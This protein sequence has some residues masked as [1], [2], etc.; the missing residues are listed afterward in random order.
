ML[1]LG[2]TNNMLKNDRD[3]VKWFNLARQ[4]PDAKIAAEASRAYHNLAAVARALSHHGVGVPDV[5]DA[6][7]RS[8]RLRAG[9]DGAASAGWFVHPYLSVR[10]V[11][12]THGAVTPGVGFAPQYLSEERGDRGARRGHAL[13]ARRD[14]MVRSRRSCALPDPRRP[15]PAAMSPDYRGGVSYAKGF[16]HLLTGESHGWFAETNDDADLRPPL[17]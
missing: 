8:V 9:E 7:A 12:D 14:R 2:W 5:L 16:G 17:R 13:L 1:K 10:F 15:I 4:S 3:A 6:L 11:G